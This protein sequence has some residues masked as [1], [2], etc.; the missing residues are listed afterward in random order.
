MAAYRKVKK[1]VAD[2]L[3]PEEIEAL[4]YS[5]DLGR[6]KRSSIKSGRQILEEM[7]ER[8]M[9]SEEDPSKLVEMLQEENLNKLA[10]IVT[11]Y[12]EEREGASSESGSKTCVE[13]KTSGGSDTGEGIVKI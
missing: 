5:M 1:Q 9:I 7:E 13:R 3:G 2:G 6:S 12:M 10:K 8:D 4:S 11:K